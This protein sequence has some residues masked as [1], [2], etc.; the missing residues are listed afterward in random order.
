MIIDWQQIDTVLLDMDGTLLDLHYDNF[1]W[2][3][4]LPTIYAQQNSLN[5]ES[6][7][8]EIEPKLQA[9]RGELKW[10]C[11][12]YWSK[13]FNLD[14]AASKAEEEV[15]N[16]IAFR[17]SAENF[18]Q[19]L[20]SLGKQ[21]WLLTNAHPDVLKIKCDRLDLAPYFEHLI[22]SHSI[23]FPKENLQFWHLV[24]EQF[25][26]DSKRSLFADDSLPILR[27]AQE[28]GIQ[29]LLAVQQPDSS[30]SSKD[31]EDY[32]SL[33]LTCFDKKRS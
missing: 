5:I 31:T 13:E 15:A 26:F 7:K 3:E 12:D 30:K 11:T 10:Y 22:S 19:H 32:D 8:R 17:P 16:K 29:K 24:K 1:Y 28:F 4:Y 6:A 14:I 18:L 33:D 27:T 20:N 21:V 9:K 25:P 23:G 2:C